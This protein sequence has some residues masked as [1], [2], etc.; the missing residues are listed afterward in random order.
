M[1]SK[2]DKLSSELDRCQEI[3]ISGYEPAAIIL[4][5]KILEDL[6][7]SKNWP[8]YVK[9]YCRTHSIFSTLSQ[10]PL[11]LRCVDKPRGYSG[12]AV[13][14][15]LIYDKHITN[16]VS[17]TSAHGKRL[18]SA[19][20][21][22][23]VCSSVNY[24]SKFI[25]KTIDKFAKKRALEGSQPISV[26]SL[27]SG[28]ARELEACESLRNGEVKHVLALDQ[29]ELSLDVL[30]TRFQGRP[31][32]GF[33]GTVRQILSGQILSDSFGKFDFI[34]SAGLYDYLDERVAT[35]LTTK[36]FDCLQP[37]G[38]LLIANFHPDNHGTA[39]MEAFMD[40]WLIY[41]S[42]EELKTVILEIDPIKISD[43]KQF[44]DPF[45]NVTYLQLERI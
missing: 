15:D 42:E 33:K 13:T 18:F 20:V 22:M 45:G 3:A 1:K 24:R 17:Q 29:D 37:G 30:R 14:L 27:A 2:L 41:R 4:V 38:V 9:D 19:L 39:Y 43:L 35:K 44:R 16:N 7:H 31:V 5:H 10:C 26:L 11:T 36:L 21:E 34:Y 40:W 12:D 23:P 25:A 8:D 6:R 28:H 32:T